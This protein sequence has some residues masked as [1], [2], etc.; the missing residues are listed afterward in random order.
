M[1]T[2]QQANMTMTVN[3]TD[4]DLAMASIVINWNAGV[5]LF[6]LRHGRFLF[7]LLICVFLTFVFASF[8]SAQYRHCCSIRYASHV[9]RS[10]DGCFDYYCLL[11]DD[12]RCD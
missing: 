3:E 7:C 11:G 1:T 5:L 10:L 2:F 6:F 12:V 4:S 9:P 8:F